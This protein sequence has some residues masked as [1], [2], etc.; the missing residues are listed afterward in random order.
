VEKLNG[1]V[2][3]GLFQ[4]MHASNSVHWSSHLDNLQLTLNADRQLH[5][6]QETPYRVMFGRD[7]HNPCPGEGKKIIDEDDLLEVRLCRCVLLNPR[8]RLTCL[9][10]LATF[11]R[12]ERTSALVKR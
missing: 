10:M 5:T 4:W 6:H 8:H 11:C 7:I 1:E 9:T 12:V 2:K 3:R